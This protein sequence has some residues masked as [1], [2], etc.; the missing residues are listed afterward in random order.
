[1][2]HMVLYGYANLITSPW[3]LI[4]PQLYYNVPA[5]TTIAVIVIIL[6]QFTQG[7]QASEWMS[8]GWECKYVYAHGWSGG[9]SP[10]IQL[11]LENCSVLPMHQIWCEQFPYTRPERQRLIII[12]VWAWKKT[13]RISAWNGTPHC[14]LANLT[15]KLIFMANS[16]KKV[17]WK[18]IHFPRISCM[19]FYIKEDYQ[20]C[21][22]FCP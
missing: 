3:N 5:V 18:T 16:F 15:G 6:S 4:F 20:N 22:V 1:M 13:H 2:S 10:W 14:L 7:S 8:L 21:I 17:C 9:L 19:Y 12:C 11:Q